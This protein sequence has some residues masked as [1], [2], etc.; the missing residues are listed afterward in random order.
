MLEGN[1]DLIDGVRR[2]CALRFAESADNAVF[3]PIQA[4]ESET[5]E[6]PLGEVRK[7]CS[8][9]YLRRS[10]SELAL[11]LARNRDHILNA[12]RDIISEFS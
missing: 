8:A 5:D 4:I 12:C 7:G 2:I 10:D 9:D 6:F 1:F 11:Y 3:F